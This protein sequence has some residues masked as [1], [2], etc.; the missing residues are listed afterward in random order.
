MKVRNRN[1]E[2]YKNYEFGIPFDTRVNLCVK[3]GDNIGFGDKLFVR[4][5]NAI[6]DSIYL[7]K[8]LGC[9]VDQCSSYITVLPGEFLSKG[10]I[11][12]E[13]V[14]SNGLTVKRIESPSSGVVSTKRLTDGY[15][16]IMGE[17]SEVVIKS[18]FSG[19][20]IYAD[21]IKGLRIQAET[22]ALDLMAISKD[23]FNSK[24]NNESIAGEF[25]LVGDGTS[26]YRV[27]DLEDDYKGK[28]VFAG[29]YVY[30]DVIKK[31]FELG[32]LCV[33][34][35]SIDYN[36]FRSINLPIGVIGGFGNIHFPSEIRKAL[37][38]MSRSFVVADGDEK[39]LFF[40]KKGDI[41]LHLSEN[42]N[43]DLIDIY[44]GEKVISY[45]PQSYGRIGI[46]IG[47][48]QETMYLTVEFQKGLNSVIALDSVDFVSL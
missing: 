4:M 43:D 37:A 11:A 17:Q 8:E 9:S 42:Q 10:D 26:V 19:K 13:R 47:Y 23:F 16:D 41:P 31:L 3:E 35:Y 25:V 2:Q 46:V 28:I 48:D 44:I 32:A 7:P 14:S 21:P 34:V 24:K 1:F 33:L 36:L 38:D 6:K 40:V 15:I 18:N 12:A 39:Q 20:V 45:D 27:S 22:T 5:E 30:E 29:K